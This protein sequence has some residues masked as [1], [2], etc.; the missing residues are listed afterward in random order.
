MRLGRLEQ[1][2]CEITRSWFGKAEN[3]PLKKKKKM[4]MMMMMKG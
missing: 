2:M 3:K 1:R 4:M